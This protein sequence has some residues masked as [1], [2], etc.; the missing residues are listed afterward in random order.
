MLDDTGVD[1]HGGLHGSC[2]TDSSTKAS[3]LRAA[4]QR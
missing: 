1:F 2:S 3:P 4:R